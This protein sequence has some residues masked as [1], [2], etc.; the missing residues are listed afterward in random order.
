VIRRALVLAAVVLGVVCSAPAAYAQYVPGEPGLALIP[1]TVAPGA[2]VQVQGF[3]CA[4]NAPVAI[5]INGTQVT[6]VVAGDNAEGSYQATITAPSTPGVY[7]VTATCGPTVVSASLTVRA[8]DPGA[9]AAASSPLPT[10]GSGLAVPLAR[11]G[12]GLLA[13]GGFM[14]LAVRQRR[15]RV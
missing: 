2:Q 10:T 12:L 9:A 5:A 14:V 3:G 4:R 11:I 6:T 7:T 1:S 15:T 8:T 13:V